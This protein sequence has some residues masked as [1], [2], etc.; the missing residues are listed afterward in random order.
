MKEYAVDIGNLSQ[1]VFPRN[2]LVRI[3]HHFKMTLGTMD[4][5]QQV[6]TLKISII[7]AIMYYRLLLRVYEAMV[8]KVT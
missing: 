1:E 6:L 8:T 5:K 2:S 4:V 3:K 7:S